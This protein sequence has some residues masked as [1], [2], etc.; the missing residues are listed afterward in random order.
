MP[1]I[2]AMFENK[3]TRERLVC[4]N[5]NLVRWFDGVAYL[6]VRKP[7]EERRFLIRRDALQRIEE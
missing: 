1:I 3:I 7:S 5:I 2:P 4:D 6:S